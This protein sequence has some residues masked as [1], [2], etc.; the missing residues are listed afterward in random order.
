MRILL[1]GYGKMGK[2]IERLATEQGHQI[3]GVID[4][5]SEKTIAD[6]RGEADVAIEFTHPE[7]AYENLKA[8]VKAQ[9]PVVCGTTGWLEYYDEISELAA[10]HDTAFFY[11]SNYS[12]GVNIFF[13]INE[14]LAK[15]MDNY[16][17][18]DVEIDETHHIHK[19][20]APSGTA[21]T[22]AEG[23]L[24]NLKR[25]SE[26]KLEESTDQA[27]NIRAH[28]E[29]EVYGKHTV[30]YDSPIDQIVITHDAHTRDGFALGAIQAALWL[31]G[32]K[33]TY[34][35]RDLLGF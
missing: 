8:S 19:K 16:P 33:G 20:D 13:A 24:D 9:I 2:T 25:K 4:V 26:W 31:V 27:I 14:Q 10:A 18:Y 23:I 7:A 29:G 34:G 3:A 1:I 28:R 30:T 15:M 32:K 5:N 21:I 22:I 6:Y 12:I 11:A 17:A 35:M